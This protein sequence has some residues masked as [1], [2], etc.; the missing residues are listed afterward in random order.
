MDAHD[1]GT[2]GSY[3]STSECVRTP[4]DFGLLLVGMLL[5]AGCG[6]PIKI[7]QPPS[8]DTSLL[9]ALVQQWLDKANR[10]EQ[11]KNVASVNH[12]IAVRS[13]ER[14]RAKLTEAAMIPDGRKAIAAVLDEEE[15]K[16]DARITDL[17]WRHAQIDPIFRPSTEKLRQR[18]VLE[19]EI[20]RTNR[21]L[22]QLLDLR[23]SVLPQDRR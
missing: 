5:L 1:S 13:R 4:R 8:V 15:K 14:A 23:A 10:A 19:A 22:S 12:W 18:S 17:T 3:R 16:L 9:P 7:K 2:V 11:T 6:S 21:H 20:R